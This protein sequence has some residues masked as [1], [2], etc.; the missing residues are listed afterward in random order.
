[1][2]RAGSC[3]VA[4]A[5]LVV[6]TVGAA[7]SNAS[8]PI[9]VP[10]H[11]E[12]GPMGDPRLGI[13][14]TIGEKAARVLVD[15]GSA[16]LRV[17]ASSVPPGSARRTGRSAAGGY[18][19]GIVLSGEE[20]SAALAFGEA[21]APSAAIELVDRIE[22]GPQRPNCPAAN[23]G[24]PEMFG[25]LFPGI[26]GI[27]IT[28]P[29][30]GRCCAN[31]LA[32]VPGGVGQTYVVHADFAAPSLTLNPDSATVGAFTMIDVPR[33]A[34]PHGCIRISSSPNETCGDVLFDTGAPQL[35]VTTT[36]IASTGAFARGTTATLTLG[37]W[38]HGIAVGPGT[39][40]RLNVRR[41][42]TNRIVV[43]LSVLQQLDVYYDIGAG[44]IGLR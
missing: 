2:A 10:L 39:D 35:L 19:S 8:G 44:R 30:R 5:A 42:D 41:G 40:V 34:L 9:V 26:L 6:G 12:R 17:L 32:A 15:T 33:G 1:V 37:P 24:T 38:T 18:A 13:D 43:G 31:P 23:G 11:V 29:P 3:V 16:G 27:S 14:V 4:A 21:R 7:G 36:G 22:C 25:G 20:A 28:D